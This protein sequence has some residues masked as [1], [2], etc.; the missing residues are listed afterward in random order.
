MMQS[1]NA[2]TELGKFFYNLALA[3][4]VSVI[5]QPLALGKP[6]YKLML[7]GLIVAVILLSIGFYI[8]SI[9][10]KLNNRDG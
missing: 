9:G 6:N 7:Y 4:L 8:I 2:L 10:D 3:V 5:I 1:K